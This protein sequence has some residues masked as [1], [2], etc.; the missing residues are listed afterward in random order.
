MVKRRWLLLV[1]CASCSSGGGTTSWD[2]GTSSDGG[3]AN[4]CGSVAACQTPIGNVAPKT[5]SEVLRRLPGRWLL[6]GTDSHK[7]GP[8]DN[9]GIEFNQDASLWW[10]LVDDGNG[11]PVKRDGF[12]S[13]GQANVVVMNDQ[14]SQVNLFTQDHG[15]Y[16]TLAALSDGPPPHLQLNSP[17]G[18]GNFVLAPSG[19]GGALDGPFSQGP[20]TTAFGDQ[21]NSWPVAPNGCPLVNGAQCSFCASLQTAMTS[22]C[23]QP[24]HRSQNDCPAAMSCV[25][26]TYVSIAGSCGD[27]DGYCM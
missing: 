12:D 21:C 17:S 25:S 11:N 7:F 23:M 26:L 4:I 14:V 3:T 9:V 20:P 13:S 10:F 24:C 6:C 1:F 2:G 5:A 16:P 15:L 18:E 8:A 22:R 27:Y 19:C